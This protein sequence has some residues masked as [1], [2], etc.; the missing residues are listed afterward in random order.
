MSV[1]IQQIALDQLFLTA[2]M[3][4][5]WLRKGPMRNSFRKISAK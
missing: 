4:N 5:D 1:P 2:R 3:Q